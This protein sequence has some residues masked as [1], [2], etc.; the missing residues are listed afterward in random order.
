MAA[1][2]NLFDLIMLILSFLPLPVPGGKAVGDCIGIYPNAM[3]YPI[4][5]STAM[6]Q[7][8]FCL[9]YDF[10]GPAHSLRPQSLHFL[11]D[12]LQ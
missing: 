8:E 9:M 2:T 3:G 1:D 7:L 5:A 12:P 6:H 11:D 10:C 4:A